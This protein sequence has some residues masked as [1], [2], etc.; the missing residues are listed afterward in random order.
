MFGGETSG[1]RQWLLIESSAEGVLRYATAAPSTRPRLNEVREIDIRDLPTFTDALQQI[2]RDAGLSLREVDCAMA[3][4]GA[5]TG[6]TISPARSRWT[7]TRSGLSA[8]FGK[9][10][11]IINDVVARAWAIRSGT[12]TLESLRGAG[13]PSL[14]N[15]GRYAMIM[16]EEGLGAA[17]IDVGRD[18][19]VHIL[20]TEGG[21]LDF[22]PCN[23][24]EEKLARAV[25]GIAPFVSWEMMLMVDRQSPV[26]AQACPELSDRE[27]AAM[28]ANIL[29]RCAVNLVHAYGA[30]QGVLLTGNRVSRLLDSGSRPSFE[31]AFNGRRQF[32]RLV[33]GCPSW[34]VEQREAVL[35][36][37]AE[38]LSQNGRMELRN[39]A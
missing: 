28:Q 23:E 22:S 25:K 3:L 20:E 36:G 10:V 15:H 39:A 33:V 21:H 37:A 31:S 27:R 8:V 18:G 38:C 35:T 9:P 34:R 29:G 12:A 2:E 24:R 11:T 30:W 6:E 19:V 13:T 17:M 26:W 32:N 16:L 14:T 7:I 5:I 1:L 4:G